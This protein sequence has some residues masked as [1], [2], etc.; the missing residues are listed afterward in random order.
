MAIE[1]RCEHCGA[2]LSADADAGAEVECPHCENVAIVPAGL[3]SLPTPQMPGQDEQTSSPEPPELPAED[4]EAPTPP[5]PPEPPADGGEYAEDEDEE[6]Y[7]YEQTGF[8]KVMTESTPWAVSIFVVGVLMVILVFIDILVRS[9]GQGIPITVPDARLSDNPGGSINPTESEISERSRTVRPTPT[10]KFS[11]KE[12]VSASSE[13]DSE[14]T[15]VIGMGAGGGGGSPFGSVGGGGGGPRSSFYG[16][17]GNAHHIVYAIDRSGSMQKFNKWQLVRK[18]LLMSISRL[19]P[20]QDFHVILFSR[21][22]SSPPE[23]KVPRQLTLFTERSQDA[24]ADFLDN[25]R[26]VEGNTVAAPALKRAFEVLRRADPKRP[27][28]VIYLL[29]DGEFSDIDDVNEALIKENKRGDVLINTF[30][31]SESEKE[32]PANTL[33]RIAKDNGGRY[34]FV[35]P[36]EVY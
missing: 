27:G 4:A 21:D 1:F 5:A 19:R 29:T 15:E 8:M 30:L 6:D 9:T 22:R 20:V 11:R 12:A 25:V 13:S 18:E 36:D 26:P 14:A 3:A 33:K 17:G 31:F 32:I 28:R 24:V 35:S 34:K 2:L 10:R 16:T 7:N 23:E